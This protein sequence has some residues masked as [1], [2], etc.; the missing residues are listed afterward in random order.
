MEYVH[1]KESMTD[2]SWQQPY[3]PHYSLLE[4]RKLNYCRVYVCVTTL[5]DITL[6]DGSTFDPHVRSG[7]ILLYSSS[8]MQLKAKQA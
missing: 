8:T 6:T 7:D 3:T 5:S 2:I 4:L 1:V